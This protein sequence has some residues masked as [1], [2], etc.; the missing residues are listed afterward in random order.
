MFGKWFRP[1]NAPEAKNEFQYVDLTPVDNADAGGIYSKALSYAFEEDRIKNIALTG[2]FGSGKSSIIKTFQKNNSYKI[3]NISLAA[4]NGNNDPRTTDDQTLLIERSI[5]QQML[6]GADASRLPYSRFKRI[7]VPASPIFY[8]LMLVFAILFSGILYQYIT[9]FLNAELFSWMWWFGSGMGLY[10]FIIATFLI[11]CLYKLAYRTSLKK[12]SFTNA[13]IETGDAS[14][15]SILNRHLDEIIYFFQQTDYDAVV[16]EDL[17]RFG[18]PEIFVK[19]REINK[20]VN[21][22]EKTS[23]KIKFLYALKDDMFAHDDRAKFFDFII[24]VVPIINSSNSLHMMDERLKGEPFEAFIDPQ[25]LREVSFYI[26]DLRLLHNIF[27]EF[28][29]YYARLKSGS[30]DVTKLL[31]MMI[32]KNSY[33]TDFEG[34]HH[35]KGA[36]FAICE[37]KSKLLSEQR[38]E[39]KREIITLRE[40]IADADNEL[41]ANIQE[42]INVYVGQIITYANQPVCGIVSNNN[43]ILF[44]Q[45]GD[46]E[47]FEPVLSENNIQLATRQQNHSSYRF[48]TN[49]SFADIEAE[50]NPNATFLDRRLR[51]EN[52][53]PAKKKE[54]RSS[55]DNLENKFFEAPQAPLHKLLQQNGVSIDDLIKK[56][57]IQDGRLLSYLIK[58]AHLDENYL[59]YT[60]NFHEGRLTKNDHDFYL[61]IRNFIQPEPR[62][63]IDTPDEV[64]KAMRSEDF[65]HKY[66]LNVE[67]M[68]Y[69]LNG[70]SENASRLESALKY[71]SQNFNKAEDFFVAYYETGKNLSC[72]MRS[73]SE[74]WPTFSFSAINSNRAAEHI[75]FILKFVEAKY[76]VEKMNTSGVLTKFLSENGHL[77]FSEG[78]KV[79]EK[80]SVLKELE[81][82]FIDLNSLESNCAL[83]EYAHKE[84]LYSIS[85]ANIDFIIDSFDGKSCSHG[86]STGEAN[87]TVLK[88]ARSKYLKKYIDDNIDQYID[89][90]LLVLPDNIHESSSAILSLLNHESVDDDKKIII[91]DKQQC[92]FKRFDGVPLSL[93][94]HVLSEEKIEITW[95]NICDYLQNEACDKELLTK[96]LGR[97][98]V[99]TYLS[100]KKITKLERDDDEINKLSWFIVS[101][102]A[103]PFEP[104][105]ELIKAVTCR[106]KNFPDDISSDKLITLAAEG[107]VGLNEDSFAF[108]GDSEELAAQL[109]AN[110]IEGYLANKDAYDVDDSLRECLLLLGMS[111]AS[112]A[113]IIADIDPAY[114]ENNHTL[115]RVISTL[116]K[117]PSIDKSLFAPAVLSVAII[118]AENIDVSIDILIKCI[119][120]STGEWTMSILKQLPSPY[121]DIALSGKRPKLQK[122][123]RNL[124]F[125]RLLEDKCLVSSVVERLGVVRINTFK[126]T[127]D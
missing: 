84:N 50:V 23:G 126:N 53:S 16:I 40:A 27:N 96:V 12:V 117:K 24:P 124:D 108:A 119:P 87:Y 36:L 33:P 32:Y 127:D 99:F 120:F 37:M 100:N 98:H 14:E 26:D 118:N 85:P 65:G 41:L 29:V 62:Q 95:S 34:L 61:T 82:K 19:L 73:L 59:I 110:N 113:T 8:P 107:K 4:F 112:K 78:F 71:I 109:I 15:N 5:L 104:Y 123:E 74:S 6:Y 115:A 70:N 94:N 35:G 90:V 9:K 60:S 114:V 102:D 44:S 105:S 92:I 17:D 86:V 22:N 25:F 121:N 42:L 106:Y 18:S 81:V 2:P 72:F 1:K 79:L 3:L 48:A 10:V 13:E 122:T 38:R 67:L 111:D 52:K 69:L 55:I 80:Y 77:V 43:M 68:D 125:A 116:F 83:V 30:L 49:K 11:S 21:D 93:W 47:K 103:I 28:T 31:S 101:N 51:I 91:I 75:S 54:L 45:I 64:C 46:F 56:C 63:K 20:L 76:I 39:I 89:K 97:Q 66:V 58:N 88:T 7:K 57:G